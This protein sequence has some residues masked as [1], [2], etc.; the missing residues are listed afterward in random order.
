MN[1]ISQSQLAEKC[2]G[3][4]CRKRRRMPSIYIDLD[5]DVWKRNYGMGGERPRMRAVQ[6]DD[7]RV[8]SGE[9][10]DR[11]RNER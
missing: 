11:M 10:T 1:N 9:R 3:K 8:M 6:V 2:S 4:R 7:L 5:F